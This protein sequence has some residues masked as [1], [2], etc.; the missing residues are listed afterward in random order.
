V[1][2]ERIRQI[3]AKALEKLRKIPESEDSGING[4]ESDA[5]SEP[6]AEQPRLMPAAIKECFD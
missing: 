6:L 3:E 5:G 2:R 4:G 1:T